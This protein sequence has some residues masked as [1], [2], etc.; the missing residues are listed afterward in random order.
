[1]KLLNAIKG[2]FSPNKPIYL[3]SIEDYIERRQMLDKHPHMRDC[4]EGLNLATTQEE[5]IAGFEDIKDMR[6]ILNGDIENK[7]T[8]MSDKP[9]TE[10]EFEHVPRRHYPDPCDR[11]AGQVR[12]V[13]M[14][15]NF[16]RIE[17]LFVSAIDG[18]RYW[19]TPIV[20]NEEDLPPIDD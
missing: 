17:F 12:D 18:T 8:T 11:F 4:I 19:A 20:V 9:I 10:V 15:S 6:E 5:W 16:I 3:P 1:M 2:W 13:K 7:D 14:R